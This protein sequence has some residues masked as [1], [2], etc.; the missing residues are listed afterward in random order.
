[1]KTNIKYNIMRNIKL[2]FSASLFLFSTTV[3]CQEA[4]NPDDFHVC[5]GSNTPAVFDIIPHNPRIG[6]LQWQIY[7][8]LNLVWINLVDHIHTVEGSLTN[9]LTLTS[10]SWAVDHFGHS[11]MVR[12]RY[13][14]LFNTYYTASADVII[15]P[16]IAITSQPIMPS[17]VCS[18]K[19][20]TLST[21]ATGPS[22]TYQWYITPNGGSATVITGAT[23]S[24]YSYTSSYPSTIPSYYCR[25]KNGCSLPT[26]KNTNTVIESTILQSPVITL[27]PPA[28]KT[29]CEATSVSISLTETHSGTPTYTWKRNG[30]NISPVQNSNTLTYNPAAMANSGSY[31]CVVTHSAS[32]CSATS[33]ACALT[34]YPKESFTQQPSNLTIGSGGTAN[35]QVT[36]TGSSLTYQWQFKSG[37][38]WPDVVNGGNVTGAT[39]NK[40]E[41]TSAIASNTFRCKVNGACTTNYYSDTA[42]LTITAA[43][44][45]TTH[46]ANDTAC[47]GS[48]A[49]FSITSPNATSYY[50]QYSV[51]GIAAYS[52]ISPTVNSNSLSV[53]IDNT[54]KD[55]YYYRCVA[56]NINGE[57]NS[58]GAM[59][60][61]KTPITITTQPLV[62]SKCI[63][64][65]AG[66][67]VAATGSDLQY[68]WYKD[69]IAMPAETD[70]KIEIPFLD[71]ANT[72]NYY[73]KL[74]NYCGTKNSNTVLFTV[75]KLPVPN[76]LGNDTTICWKQKVT[77]DPGAYS[78]Y[79]WNTG[80]TSRTLNADS[81][82]TYSVVVTD[83]NGCKAN[84]SRGINVLKP[85]D[86]TQICLVT[87]DPAKNKNK[88]IWDRVQ[89]K[90]I[91]SYNIYKIVGSSYEKLGEVKMDSLSVFVDNLSSPSIKT[92]QYVLK[93]VDSCGN[94]SNKSKFVST[95]LLQASKGSSNTEANLLW[96]K[97]IDE[98][99]SFVPT[100]YYIWKGKTKDNM[101][102]A[103]IDSVSGGL[104]PLY[105]DTHFDGVSAFY[106]L[107][108]RK[109]SACAPAILKA[110]S[111]PYSQ[112]LSNITE[113]KTT[114]LGN[115]GE[116]PVAVY[117]NPVGNAFT[118]VC[119]LDESGDVM[120]EICDLTGKKIFEK[121]LKGQAAGECKTE[122]DTDNCG[123]S[124][125]MY[126]V[127]VIANGKITVIK[128]TCQK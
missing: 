47:V 62:Q 37:A 49:T 91:V 12:C 59:L 100:Y 87:F 97:Y 55:G 63:N 10:T 42:R 107:E 69:A 75:N 74:T 119:E 101:G 17:G 124:T 88:V 99:G 50:W 122:L 24:T 127:K 128:I 79:L 6:A 45:I 71:S 58:D 73:C 86:S 72:G 61:V 1:M 83:A 93:A 11:P 96:S 82:I 103:P 68:L 16:D 57:T 52:T 114:A 30:S 5:P 106:K 21:V 48:N 64:D 60:T 51:N 31:N 125:G 76:N 3:F 9:T 34:M 23:N 78:S 85:W 56:V 14:Y 32:I 54:S 46:P 20:I 90:R 92:D 28:T 39:T 67:T 38:S 41:I 98:S 40:L 80:A 84:A 65:S 95:M 27:Q 81:N 26:Y 43:P 18:G 112:S 117:P 7:D 8:F 29:G 15:R 111:G 126:N 19:T 25:I 102:T 121:Q 66:L 116:I 44:A 115:T 104:A 53:S 120:I 4:A 113:Y 22:L 33:T 105:I 94:E 110:E 77:L 35:F 13:S 36:V 70:Y 123:L 108:I 109:P 2:L 118:I 89:N